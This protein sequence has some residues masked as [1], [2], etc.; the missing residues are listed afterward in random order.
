MIEVKGLIF[1]DAALE[2]YITD[3]AS[4]VPELVHY[5]VRLACRDGDGDHLY[6]RMVHN[7]SKNANILGVLQ[8]VLDDLP[9]DAFKGRALWMPGR[10]NDLPLAL[11]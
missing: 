5:N 11:P 3:V 8:A 10:H 6:Q 7:V 1:G 9:D 2:V 4:S